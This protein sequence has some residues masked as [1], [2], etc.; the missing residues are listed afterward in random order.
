MKKSIILLIVIICSLNLFC[1]GIW[2]QK[3]DYGGHARAFAIVF[4]INNI[5]YVGAGCAEGPINNDY[6]FWAY[7][8]SADEWSEKANVPIYTFT[9]YGF[10]I[11][12]YGYTIGSL[13][14]FWR[15]DP[16]SDLWMQKNDFPG[17][18]RHSGAITFSLNGK[19]YYGLGENDQSIL[20]DIWE[21]DPVSDQWTQKNDFPTCKRA[22]L[23][24]V[25]NNQAYIGFGN[26]DT[27]LVTKD[28]WKYDQLPDMWIKKC[29]FPGTAR[30]FAT[31]FSINDKGYA[32]TGVDE[33]WNFTNDFWEYDPMLD[34]WIQIPNLS[35]H[36]RQA[37]VG[38]S[39]NNKGYVTTGYYD[40]LATVYYLKDLWEYTSTTSVNENSGNYCNHIKCYPNPARDYVV[41]E[42]PSSVISSCTVIPNT[43]AGTSVSVR[44]PLAI[45]ITNLFGQEVTKLPVKTEKTVWDTREVKNGIYFY[46]VELEGKVVSGKLVLI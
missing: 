7:D 12:Q 41:F 20:K 36:T 31:G 22:A 39:I 42:L 26:T 8:P 6:E 28:F 18:V 9:V 40:Q 4:V 3:A 10:S 33:N 15:Y 27:L 32:G 21:Y 23:A 45:R 44:N 34:H 19:G 35:G 43:G 5:A 16:V 25:I 1:Q 14:E 30:Q 17:P 2:T 37:A 13:N 46:R 38:F 11:D 29:D 24:L